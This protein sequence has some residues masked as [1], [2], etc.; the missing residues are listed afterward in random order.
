[1]DEEA[2]VIVPGSVTVEPGVLETI[3]RLTALGVPGVVRIAEKDVDRLL[4]ISGKSVTVQVQE[5]QVRV[6]LHLIAGPNMSLLRL[7]QSVQYEVTRAIQKMIGMPVERVDVYI[8]DV[9]YPQ[10]ENWPEAAVE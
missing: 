10:P 8:E 4:G 9:V 3:A 1:M 2:Q 6:D 5:G 7:G